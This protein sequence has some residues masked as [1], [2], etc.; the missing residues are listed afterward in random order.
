M[1]RTA[2]HSSRI[3]EIH[4]IYTIVEVMP[5]KTKDGH[6]L[7]KGVCN[8]CGYEKIARYNDFTDRKAESCKHIKPDGTIRNTVNHW[9]NS[10]IRE[11]Y[12]SLVRRCRKDNIEVYEDWLTNPLLFES[13]SLSNGYNDGLN[14]LRKDK[15]IGYYPENCIWTN[16]K[17]TYNKNNHR[18]KCSVCGEYINDKNIS[19]MCCG[20]LV[21]NKHEER[22]KTWLETGNTG[23][24][25]SSKVPDVIRKYILDKQN[26]RCA[27]CGMQNLWNNKELKFILDH[28]N[29]DAANNYEENLRLICPNCDSQL[30]TYKS[31][32]KNSARIYRKKYA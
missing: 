29:G 2:N 4:G 22:I 13:W 17:T 30:D 24:S 32:N 26:S 31:K 9:K 19:G 23:T 12:Y 10:K 15:T 5:Y 28:I 8:E 27:I 21:K 20:C 16:R 3:G 6:T 25:V 18:R 1:G 11:I 14:L 7:Y